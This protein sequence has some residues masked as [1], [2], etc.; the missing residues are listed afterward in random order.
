MRVDLKFG[1]NWGD[2]KHTWQELHNGEQSAPIVIAADAALDPV[3]DT[4]IEPPDELVTVAAIPFMITRTMKEQLYSRGF[5][6]QDVVEMTPQQAHDQLEIESISAA[7]IEKTSML[8][9]D[10]QP[11][12][13]QRAPEEPPEKQPARPTNGASAGGGKPTSGNGHGY[14]W[15]EDNINQEVAEFIYRNLKGDPY[16]KVVKHKTK[17]G[18]K[19][20]PQ[21]HWENGRWESGKPKG[22]AIPYRLPELLAAPTA[23]KVWICEGEKDANTLAALGLIATTNPGGAT[24]WAPELN[25]WLAGYAGAYILED[26]DATGRKHV[27]QVATAL[28]EVIFDIPI[29][30]FRELPEHGDVTDWMQAGGTLALLLERANL[31]PGFATL[32]STCAADEAVEAIDWI[33]FGR[34]AI[35]KIGLL[36]GL[37]DEGKGLTLSDII[38]RITRA[39]PWPCN[40]GQAPLGNVILLTA[41]DD[42]NDT[43]VPRLLAA[44]TDLHRVTIVKMM[45]EAGK[46]RM[47]SLVS[48]LGALRQKVV[49]IGDVRM[50]VIDPITAYLGIGKVD[51]FRATDV[52]AVLSPL[53]EL[54]AELRLSIL[55]VMHFNKK[56]DITNVLLRISDSLAYGAA[57]R[58]VYG[59][60]DDP[61][62]H[63]KL[64]VK[65]KNNLAP[66]DQKTLAFS[67]DA[68]EIGT[69][70]RTGE[71]IRAPY[72][73]GIRT[74]LTSPPRKHCRR[75]QIQIA[76]RAR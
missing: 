10:E 36:V 2:A 33:W 32:E 38:A 63:R 68:R 7:P 75:Q 20:F 4:S 43:V 55:G 41:E 1:R 23:T 67:F 71:P 26:N 60:I 28:T 76:G 11:P 5:S 50:I 27:L 31:A 46:Q 47:F 42:I 30:S 29:L 66:K 16:L 70:K 56:V 73:C 22:P 8:P 6:E 62:K 65:G 15:G 72:I 18:R 53:K 21:Y 14:P 13:A 51:S 52:R 44:G 35:G 40:E 34:Y 45:H 37:P 12:S 24:K 17:Q 9:P 64:F 59:V 54:A 3:D 19:S 39:S 25:K 48:D 49:E 57:A 69:D 61:D 58:H 74:R